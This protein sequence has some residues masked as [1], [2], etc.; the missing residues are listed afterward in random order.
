[1]LGENDGDLVVQVN[2][3]GRPGLGWSEVEAAIGGLVET[4]LLHHVNLAVVVVD[5][6]GSVLDAE[7]FTR[8][9]PSPAPSQ[10]AAGNATSN[11]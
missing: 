3:T 5:A 4:E 1:L 11:D 9:I 2:V 10:I 6:A 7:Y 8:R